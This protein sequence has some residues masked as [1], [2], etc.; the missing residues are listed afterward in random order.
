M[1]RSFQLEKSDTLTQPAPLR[2]ASVFKLDLKSIGWI[3]TLVPLAITLLSGAFLVFQLEGAEKQIEEEVKARRILSHIN[4]LDKLSRGATNFLVKYG[5][6]QDPSYIDRFEKVAGAINKEFTA[7]EALIKDSP[8]EVQALKKFKAVSVEGLQILGKLKTFITSRDQ[9]SFLMA[10]QELLN[11]TEE[12]GVQGDEL[13]SFWK[14]IEEES[15]ARSA[16]RRQTIFITLA[17]VFSLYAIAAAVTFTLYQSIKSRIGTMTENSIR[18]AT[19][20]P[21]NPKLPGSDELAKLDESFHKMAA[22]LSELTK[23]ERGVL[24]HARDVICSLD[25]K[26]RFVSVSPASLSLWGYP[27]EEVR[28]MYISE[29]VVPADRELTQDAIRTVVTGQRKEPFENR[30]VRKDGIQVNMLWS[31]HW[32]ADEGTLACVVHD[33]TDRKRAEALLIESEERVRSVIENMPVAVVVIDFRGFIESINPRTV[34]IFEFAP[35]ALTG[36]HIQMLF[37]DKDGRPEALAQSIRE[38]ALGR[39]IELEGK[40]RSGAS[41]PV[42]VTVNQF[43]T[44]EGERFLVSMQDVTE[45][46]EIER[47]KQEFVAMVSHDLRTPLSAV[48]GT[49]ELLTEGTYGA[50]NDLGQKRI[51]AAEQSIERLINLINDLLDIEKL[52]AGKLAMELAPIKL[53]VVIERSVEAVRGYAEQTAVAI[54]QSDMQPVNAQ[55]V[56]DRDRLVQVFVNLLSNAIKFSPPQSSVTISQRVMPGWVEL[57][58]TDKGR[59]IPASHRDSIFE[60]FKQVETADGARS[61][62]TGLGLAICKAIVESHGGTIGVDSEEGRGSS[63]W[64]R[65][66][67]S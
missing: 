34:E 13:A 17:S 48:R 62:G 29:L 52:E 32:T 9:F 33:I 4:N 19:G 37:S 31:A 2:K 57:R 6:T 51:S 28:G 61:K 12:L 10:F 11:I 44:F 54:Q 30:L 36:A 24:E 22:A 41:F 14:Q 26:G 39:A 42:E 45:R 27:P 38:K 20:Q 53:D 60:R 35:D 49:L 21:L 15:S 40:R 56:G 67:A 8:Q 16:Q 23:R 58:V 3:F 50:L 43:S 64:V 7:L 18:L 25:A 55:V 66:P 59:G 63:F 65:L 47:L 46:H 5:V 1:V